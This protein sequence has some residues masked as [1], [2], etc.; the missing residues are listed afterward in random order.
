MYDL[1]AGIGYEVVDSLTVDI[2][3][4]VGY[5][6]VNLRLDDLD[7]L[8]SNLDFKGVFAGVELHF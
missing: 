4:K 2:R 7:N 6:A 3:L 8:Y 1:Q 5:R